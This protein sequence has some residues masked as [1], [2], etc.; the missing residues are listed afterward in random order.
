MQSG[1]LARD[2]VAALIAEQAK[3]PR[4]AGRGIACVRS[5]GPRSANRGLTDDM[6]SAC[7][8]GLATGS[9]RS[10]E[11]TDLHGCRNLQRLSYR[12]GD[13]AG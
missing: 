5:T 12:S 7:G 13:M 3:V 2:I 6:A 4:G 10:A 8:Y 1:A 11:L 9:S